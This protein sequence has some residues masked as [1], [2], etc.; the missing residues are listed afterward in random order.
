MAYIAAAGH[1]GVHSG[2]AGVCTC[3]GAGAEVEE[4]HLLC[5]SSGVLGI[6]TVKELL[7]PGEAEAAMGL[8]P[9]GCGCSVSVVCKGKKS[10][11]FFKN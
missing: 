3:A 9:E 2:D 1:A 6:W 7:G 11:K 10:L 5:L 4:V 8:W